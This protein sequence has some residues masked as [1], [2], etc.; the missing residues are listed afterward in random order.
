[1]TFSRCDKNVTILLNMSAA[2]MPIYGHVK[3]YNLSL[4][5][6]EITRMMYTWHCLGTSYLELSLSYITMFLITQVDHQAHICVCSTQVMGQIYITFIPFAESPLYN[7]THLSF[8]LTIL[9]SKSK[10]LYIS[11]CHTVTRWLT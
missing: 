6:L 10:I 5:Y 3:N 2:N 4:S 7:C 8:Q 1:M 11:V 9:P